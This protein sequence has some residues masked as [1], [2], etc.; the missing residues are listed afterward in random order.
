MKAAII[1]I[2][3]EILVGQTI[4][5]NSAYIAKQ[6]REIGVGINEIRSISDTRQ[7]IIEALD[8]FI[9]T[10]DLIF[11]T[12][13][14]GPTNDDIT[15]KV[16]TEYF[17]GELKT[18]ESVLNKIQ[19]YFDSIH[20][21]MLPVHRQQAE[22]PTS[23]EIIQNDFG[24]ASGMW[25]EK[26]ETHVISMPGVPYEMKGLMEKIIPTL[27]ERF[28][29]GEFYHRTVLFQGVRE[30]TLA[31]VMI[32]VEKEAHQNGAGMAFL[33][34]VSIVKIRFTGNN[35]HKELFEK[36]VKIA[37]ERF[38]KNLFGEE[39]IKLEEV[40]GNLLKE[41]GATVGT[42][43]SCTSGSLSAKIVSVPGAS[44]YYLGSLITYSY[45]VKSYLGNVPADLIQTKGAVSEEVVKAMAEE[46][47]N[48]LKVDYCLSTSGIAGPG[49]GTPD[50]PVGTVWIGL[51]S[52]AGVKARKFSFRQN[53]ERNI[54]QTISYALNML[55]REL[56]EIN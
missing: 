43:E 20:R 1:T 53:R 52:P 16:L 42:V 13:G 26:D 29:I 35:R 50:K 40:I 4:D 27:V 22:L 51:A 8:D 15:K 41:R 44:E 25:F 18:N 11:V 45:D 21:E 24:T 38:P 36:Y 56:L 23:A 33:P 39:E 3:D 55:R 31:E 19:S 28:D 34:S 5:T 32:D 17:G 30:S 46:G 2:G 9:E 49:G 37:Y 6:L 48:K 12:G 7:A 10:A 47:R 54:E 14:L